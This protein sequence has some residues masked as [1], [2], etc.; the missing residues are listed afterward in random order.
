MKKLKIGIAGLSRGRGFVSV[1]S[2]HPDVTISAICDIDQKKLAEVGD[3]FALPDH[4]RY[5][6]FDDFVNGD[7]DIVMIATP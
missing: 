1:F 7:M 6:N 2:S 3:V 5:T 4:A